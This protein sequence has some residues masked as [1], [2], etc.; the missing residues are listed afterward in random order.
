MIQM[1]VVYP[2]GCAIVRRY[3][4]HEAAD[5]AVQAHGVRGAIVT[6]EPLATPQKPVSG[7]VGGGA[8]HAR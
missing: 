6:V 5:A 8:T 1:T 3:P 4:S 2:N 7:H